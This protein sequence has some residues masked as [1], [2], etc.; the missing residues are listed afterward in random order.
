M[1]HSQALMLLSSK[2]FEGKVGD[3]LKSNLEG[4]PKFVTLEKKLGGADFNKT[5]L[6]GPENGAG[7]MMLYTSGTTNR[8]VGSSV[9]CFSYHGLIWSSRKA[10][11]F[12]KL[13]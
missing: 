6:D 11:C 12:H 10:F 3:L 7:G 8:P 2:K 13:S 4:N 5:S 1:D 9:S